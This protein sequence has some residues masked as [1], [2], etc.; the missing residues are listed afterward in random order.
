MLGLLVL[1]TVA[2]AALSGVAIYV[3]ARRLAS[4][5]FWTQKEEAEADFA[6]VFEAALGDA[7]AQKRV[8]QSGARR[9]VRGTAP[10]QQ[11]P[12][13]HSEFVRRELGLP[14]A[15]GVLGV[16]VS[17]VASVLSLLVTTA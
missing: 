12:L 14:A 3:A 9:R 11:R 15:L 2:G 5:R 7:A 1:L 8:A 16:F 6:D 13:T 17:A 10:D 4:A